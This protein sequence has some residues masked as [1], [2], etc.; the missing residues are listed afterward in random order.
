MTPL[1]PLNSPKRQEYDTTR[2][3]RFF[4]AWDAK[5]N[6]A[7]VGQ[8]CRKLDFKLP[9]ST[10]RRWIKE[11]DIQGSPAIRRTRKQASR[12]GRKSKVSASDLERLTNQQDPIHKEP[13]EIQAETLPGEPSA[14]TLQAHATQAG[15]K[16]FKKRYTTEISAKNKPIRVEYGKTHENKTLTGFWQQVAFTDEFHLQSVKL[17]NKAEYGLRFPGQETT[18]KETKTTG[19]NVTVH[20]A[21]LITYNR[22]GKLIFY[23]DPQEPSQKAYKPRKPRQTMYQTDTQYKDVLKAWEA[24]QPDAEVIPKGNAMSQQFYAKEILPEYIKQIKALEAH[25]HKRFYLQE[26]G[27]PSHGNKSTDNPCAR[28]KRDADLLI[29]IHPAQSPDLNPIEACW[30]IIKQR[31]RGGSW[32]TVEEFKAAIQAEWDRITITQIR[33]RIRE[34]RWRCKR[35]QQLKGERIRSDLW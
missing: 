20:A 35:V 28:L 11:R 19:L 13:Y 27:D 14:R 17:Q 1:T 32:K 4:D 2:R 25:F 9:P 8:I 16:R 21:G 31:L 12:L 22:K 5:E 34:M 18:L 30:Q 29:L 15:A 26:D 3:A 24:A 33:R 7:G 23:K 6:D 10:A